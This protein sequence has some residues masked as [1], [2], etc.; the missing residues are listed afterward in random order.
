MAC[1]A[2]SASFRSS[3]SR[4]SRGT[5]TIAFYSYCGSCPSTCWLVFYSWKSATLRSPACIVI[6]LL[7]LL[8]LA[9][10]WLVPFAI[11]TPESSSGTGMRAAVDSRSFVQFAAGCVDSL[12]F[13]AFAAI[14]SYLLALLAFLFFVVYLVWKD[15]S[16]TSCG[17]CMF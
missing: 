6:L 17:A 16:L 15:P 3:A 9:W 2:A 5:F 10:P 1:A 11:M 12:R 13:A 4:T 8:V 7:S 14:G